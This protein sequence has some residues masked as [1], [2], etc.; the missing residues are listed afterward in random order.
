MNISYSKGIYV[1]VIDCTNIRDLNGYI[2]DNYYEFNLPITY[3]VICKI[4]GYLKID[5]NKDINKY[6]KVF[7][8]GC[9][10][11]IVSYKYQIL[12][13]FDIDYYR[14]AFA[15]IFSLLCNFNKEKI[16]QLNI[17]LFIPDRDREIINEKL[18][19][20]IKKSKINVSYTLCYICDSIIDNV[21]YETKCY[22][23]S[24]YI[25]KVSNFSRLLVGHIIDC[26]KLLYLDSDT[27]V[28]SDV[29]KLLDK[30]VMNDIAMFGKKSHLNYL[31][32]INIKN[33][34]NVVGFVGNDFNLRKKVINTGTLI[35]NTRGVKILYPKIIE[36]IRTHNDT[37]GG[38]YKLFT[39]SII[40]LIFNKKIAYFDKYINNIVGL[41]FKSGL[42][43]DIING[44][45]LDWNGMF[46]P[47]LIDGLYKEY[48]DRYDLIV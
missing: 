10:N 15:S 32:I 1:V 41:G 4:D 29:S 24:E 3:Y 13:S 22:N 45:V 18:E 27:I 5:M 9:P 19:E 20:F 34:R 28:Q 39:M 17:N 2:N 36:I 11:K 47:W 8:Y 23:S 7:P 14:G 12:Y 33:I 48:W 30:I 21:I 42:E 35:M 6:I 37:E 44:D 25:L 40:N 16:D 26:E 46:K 43:N 31:N 38:L